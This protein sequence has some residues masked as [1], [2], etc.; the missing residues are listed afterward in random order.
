MLLSLVPLLIAATFACAETRSTPGDYATIQQAVSDSNPDIVGIVIGNRAPTADAGSS[1]Y[2]A[3]DPVFL[4][5]TDSFDRD[6]YGELTYE[7]RQA[8]GQSLNIAD[9][10]TATP[11]I[12]GFTQTSKIQRCVFELTVS[13]GDLLSKPDTVEVIVVPSFGSESLFQVNPPFDPNKPTIVTFFGQG[14]WYDETNALTTASY[15]TPFSQYGDILVVYLSSVA[16][17][18]TQPI[19]ITGFSSGGRWAIDVALRVNEAYADGRFAVN[20]VS[21]LDAACPS[22]YIPRFV[23]SAVDGEPCWIDNYYATNTPYR[24]GVLNVKFPTRSAT[25]GTPPGWFGRSID[26]SIWPGGDLHNSGVTAGYYVSVAGPGKNLR[27]APDANDY[28]FEWNS[29]TDY[30]EFYDESRYPARIPKPATLKGPDDGAILDANGA[31]FSC[32]ST[33]GAVRYQL[34][35]GPDP[36]HLDY[37]VSDTRVPPQELLA[38]FPF[39]ITYWTVVTTDAHGAT[40]Y[41]DPARIEPENVQ[42]QPIENVTTGKTYPSIQ[43]AINDA[44]TGDEIVISPGVYRHFE[45]IDFR[46]KNVTLRSIDPNDPDVVL[47][48]IING[49]GQGAVVTFS[50]SEDANS[51]LAGLTI[52]GAEWGLYCAGASPTVTHCVI[53]GNKSA[54]IRLWKLG[55]PAITHCDI[56]ANSGIGIE[57]VLYK[58]GRYTLSNYPTIANCVVAANLQHGISG[59]APTITN[60]TIVDNLL[61]GIDSSMATVTNSIIYFNGDGSPDA[62]ISNSIATLSYTDVRGAWPGVGNIDADPYFISLWDWGNADDPNASAEIDGDYHLKSTG[63]RWSTEIRAWTSDDVTSPCIDAG[64]PDSPLGAEL[65]FL[66]V[67]PDNERGENLRINMGAHGGTM[68][69]SLAPRE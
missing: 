3:V 64:D 33:D 19:Q 62:Q 52:T 58:S 23:A 18:Y 6:G 2:A 54:G 49:R 38:V 50:S 48:T 27:L 5:G 21:L 51:V 59:G 12:S 22:D 7:W 63:A 46:G 42:E 68:E 34:L 65:Q 26:A 29:T 39:E 11:T 14:N 43:S 30:L 20:R 45:N 36:Q 31:V 16:P 35:L 44:E 67:G 60:C 25:H 10:N 1:R 9:A 53:T 55:N 4:D 28:Y 17:D 24:L 56:V 57:M 37:V 61:N 8:S 69:A 40:I 66:S 13:D 41:S 47:A 32:E 15:A